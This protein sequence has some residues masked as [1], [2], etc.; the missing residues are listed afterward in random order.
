[1]LRS[2]IIFIFVLVDFTDLQFAHPLDFLCPPRRKNH[3][4][5]E[6]PYDL[7]L[8]V[9]T[10]DMIIDKVGWTNKTKKQKN[11]K[12]RTKH[13]HTHTLSAN[14]T[15]KTTFFYVNAFPPFFRQ[16]WD[17]ERVVRESNRIGNILITMETKSSKWSN[18]YNT[19]ASR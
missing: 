5:S 3:R 4:N 2:V 13:T 8:H 9:K 18:Q 12:K 11:K 7:D 17:K 6:H 15:Q 14:V 10:V 16:N 1:M 19:L